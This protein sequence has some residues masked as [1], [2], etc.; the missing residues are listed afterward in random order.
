MRKSLRRLQRAHLCKQG[1][2]V[3]ELRFLTPP[4]NVNNVHQIK[5]VCVNCHVQW[6]EYHARIFPASMA[7]EKQSAAS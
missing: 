3:V 4:D 1:E 5:Y 7:E 6:A 2:H